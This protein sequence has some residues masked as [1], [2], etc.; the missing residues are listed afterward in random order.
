VVLF[1]AIKKAEGI[2]KH[3]AKRNADIF[4]VVSWMKL[5]T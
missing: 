2:E 5:K 1:A 4:I 3:G